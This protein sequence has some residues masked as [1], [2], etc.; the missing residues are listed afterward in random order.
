MDN[1]SNI[2]RRFIFHGNSVA[3]AA[4]VRRPD[5]FFIPAVAS[6]CLPVTGGLAEAASGSQRF[7]NIISF[8][9]ASSRAHG[10]YADAKRAA[11]FTHGNFTENQL[12][13]NTFVE[14]TLLGL[15]F[16][17]PQD[18]VG[19]AAAVIRR[20]SVETLHVRL[21]SVSD[22]R[23]PIAF[24]SL[25][26]TIDG[27]QVDGHHLKVITAAPVF[28]QHDTHAKL[29]KAFEEDSEF[30]K[31]YAG[32]FYP[33]GHEKTGL[34]GLLSKHEIPNVNGIIVGTVVTG[35]EW[36]DN[37]GAPDTVISGNRL[38]I[39]GIGTVFFG[40]IIIE[41]NFRRVTLLRFQLGSPYG[42]DG[43]A[44]EVQSNGQDWP[45]A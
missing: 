36:D 10:D 30:R 32:C 4:H 3:F 26:T 20:F 40:E 31:Q 19:D 21:E 41:Q 2:E 16:E 44:C 39:K 43:S 28:G 11:D 42:A 1:N 6:S 5:D 18:P 14:S 45:P 9:S 38:E 7:K 13:T 35:L 34:S 23:N 15:K 29:F 24:R 27:V 12:A 25:E 17:I 37:K 33:T 8:Q 22:R